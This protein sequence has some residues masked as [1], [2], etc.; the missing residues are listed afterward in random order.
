[1]SVPLRALRAFVLAGLGMAL[2]GAVAAGAQNPDTVVPLPPVVVSTFP[3]PTELA[4]APAAVTV[5]DGREA[6]RASPGT[7]LRDLLGPVPGLQADDR[8]NDALDDRLAIRGFG[9]RAQFGVRGLAVL[10]DGVPATLPDGQTALSHLDPSSVREV[11]VIRGPASTFVGN[12]GGG[13]LR[14]ETAP[15]A[16]ELRAR[17]LTGPDGLL[18]LESGAARRVGSALVSG[19]LARRRS[20]GFRDHAE[21]DRRW[22]SGHLT[23]PAAGGRLRFDVHGVDYDASNPGSLTDS[24]FRADPRAAFPRNVEQGTGESGRQAQAGAGWVGD[25]AR[26]RLEAGAW[27]LSRSVDNPIPAVVVDLRRRSWGARL[28][29]SGRAGRLGWAVGVDGARQSDDRLNFANDGGTKG[30]LVLD[31][32]E[33]DTA[34]APLAQVALEA[35]PARLSVAARWD[36]VRF[37]VDDRLRGVSTGRGTISAFSPAAGIVLD[38]GRATHAFANV[39]TAFETPTASEF[40][41]DPAGTGFN[42]GLMPQRTVGMEVGARGA[43]GGRLR[44][45][46]VA[47]HARVRDALVPFEG[48]DGR[49]FFRNA[50]RT[51]HAG[52]EAALEAAWSDGVSLHAAYAWTRVEFRRFL[53]DGVE[54]RGRAVPGVTPHAVDAALR[55]RLRGSFGELALRYRSPTAVDDANTAHR[56]AYVVADLR[57]E[58]PPVP[59]GGAALRIQAGVRNLTDERYAGSI[60]PNAFGAR[61]FEPAPGRLLHVGIEVC[62]GRC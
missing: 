33:R 24:A 60:V 19:R 54:L 62:E 21:A 3:L 9:S 23:A 41:N 28:R 46:A 6:T 56:P 26:G 42:A 51:R 15:A 50:G 39:S 27:V 1:M 49:T 53:S 25:A 22:G 7:G 10:V 18:R 43:P 58:T 29:Y 16:E 59:F 2:P 17:A 31:Q 45:E 36:A 14:I 55:V 20:D 30:E 52:L 61:Y 34:L 40:A 8:H 35:G 5:V 47:H 48:E 37:D 13:A 32:R 38:V 12:A 4:G 44:W 57:A 11:E